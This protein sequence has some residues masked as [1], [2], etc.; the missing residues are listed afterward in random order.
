MTLRRTLSI[1]VAL[2]SAACGAILGDVPEGR[3][4]GEDASIRDDA[5][6]GDDAETSAPEPA[7]EIWRI[8]NGV[9]LDM[10]IDGTSVFWLQG[11]PSGE[12]GFAVKACPKNGGDARTIATVPTRPEGLALSDKHAFWSIS[13][14][15]QHSGGVWRAEKQGG[16][17][18]TAQFIKR[19]YAGPITVANGILI[20]GTHKGSI[21]YDSPEDGETHDRYSGGNVVSMGTSSSDLYW[22]LQE[23]RVIL[24][25]PT[26]RGTWIA[27]RFAEGF[28][29]PPSFLSFDNGVLYWA[30]VTNTRTTI[31]SKCAA[32]CEAKEI[33]TPAAGVAS[34]AV[35]NGKLYWAA[36]EQG[37]AVL[38]RCTDLS[39]RCEPT[40]P[41]VW[42]AAGSEISRIALDDT[43]VYFVV[44]RGNDT[45]IVKQAH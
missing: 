16:Q 3:A 12:Q 30:V 19:E 6:I 17:P 22:T 15:A 7:V 18:P 11:P 34:L 23:D 42:S 29:S 24:T 28:S 10:A 9:V 33:V 2:G 31:S 8:E 45:Y 20:T 43:D 36:N 5:S 37:V 39:A 41:P 14:D 26:V 35:R 1:A 4:V 40:K 38:R 13:Q 21:F 44:R 32:G 27:G 25:I